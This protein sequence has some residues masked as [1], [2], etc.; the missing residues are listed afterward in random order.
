MKGSKI[1]NNNNTKAIT[2]IKVQD[3]IIYGS[4][5]G[6]VDSVREDGLVADITMEEEVEE[7]TFGK[8]C[9][10]IL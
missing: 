4:N 7:E 2:N 1:N 10:K 9:A 3:I 6:M 5:N 8:M